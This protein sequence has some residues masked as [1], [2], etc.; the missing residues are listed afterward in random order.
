MSAYDLKSYELAVRLR[1]RKTIVVE[2]MTDKQVLARLLTEHEAANG[3]TRQCVID[4]ISIVSREATFAG[5]GN[6]ERVLRAGAQIATQSPKMKCLVDREWDGLDLANLKDPHPPIPAPAWGH[7]THGHSIENY[8]FTES[9]ACSYLKMAYGAELPGEYFNEF[10]SRFE[11]MLRVAAAFS[12]ATQRLSLITTSGQL[13]RHEHVQWIT[14]EYLPT[15]LLAAAGA[16]RGMTVDLSAE[17]LSEFR[18]PDFQQLSIESLQWLCHG[19]LGDQMLRSCA[20]NLAKEFGNEGI[21]RAIERG[22]YA[23]KLAH[24]ADWLARSTPSKAAP[25][26]DLVVWAN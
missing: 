25:L 26:D 12:L 4:E 21:A 6:R 22:F 24:D 20:A 19:H 5:L 9:A 17:I 10:S 11:A 13:L 2:G 1:T 15:G 23:T 7:M 3:K 8:W 16:A 14:G 18:R